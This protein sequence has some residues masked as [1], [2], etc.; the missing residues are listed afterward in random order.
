M[1][2]IDM[3]EPLDDPL[4]VAPLELL[5]EPEEP[6]D[7]PLVEVPV[8]PAADD[9]SDLAALVDVVATIVED[10]VGIIALIPL[11]IVAVVT[12]L[13]EAGVEYAA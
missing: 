13:D 8:L 4:V 6:D 1:T 5:V 2:I 10:V 12:Q 11:E 7:E 9:V 3:E